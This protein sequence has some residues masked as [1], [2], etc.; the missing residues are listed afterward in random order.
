MFPCFSINRISSIWN[1]CFACILEISEQE[2]HDQEIENNIR[3]VYPRLLQP[4]KENVIIA[5]AK[6]IVGFGYSS[7]RLQK[8]D[9]WFFTGYNKN[10]LIPYAIT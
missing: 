9:I 5:G 6:Q 10:D 1:S 4:M 3:K 7:S 8:P 2:T